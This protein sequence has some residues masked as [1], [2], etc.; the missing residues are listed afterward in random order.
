MRLTL[1]PVDAPDDARRAVLEHRTHRLAEPAPDLGSHLLHLVTVLHPAPAA[2]LLVEIAQCS[3]PVHVA[4]ELTAHVEEAPFPATALGGRHDEH[5]EWEWALVLTG[6]PL[7]RGGCRVRVSGHG[8]AECLDYRLVPL[9]AYWAGRTDLI[10][11][12]SD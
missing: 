8:L 5:G 4:G 12:A 11:S 3:T 6:L 7:E 10:G 9:D 2:R 1:E